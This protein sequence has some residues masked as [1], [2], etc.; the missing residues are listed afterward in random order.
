[1]VQPEPGPPLGLWRGAGWEC[2]NPW[3]EP[4]CLAAGAALAQTALAGDP[5][6][7]WG[8]PTQAVR[9]VLVLGTSAFWS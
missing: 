5:A 7:L 1:M 2:S 3:T 8:G 9:R 6:R 4:S